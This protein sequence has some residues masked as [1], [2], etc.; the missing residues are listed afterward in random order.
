MNFLADVLKTNTIV[1]LINSKPSNKYNFT[2]LEKNDTIK[3]ALLAF[4]KHEYTSMPLKKNDSEFAGIIKISNLIK[5]IFSQ[6]ENFDISTLLE[7]KLKNISDDFIVDFEYVDPNMSL[8]QLLIDVWNNSCHPKFTHIECNHLLTSGTNGRY[9]IITP[10]DFL[11]YVLFICQNRQTCLDGT[12]A[13]EIENG[14]DVEEVFVVSWNDEA[15]MAMERVIESEPHYLVAVVNEE[16]GTLEANITFTDIFPDN[17]TS[18]EQSI[19]M[20]LS[21]GMSLYS[22]FNSI[23]A[24]LPD[25]SIDP[26]LLYPHFTIYDLIEKLTRLRIHHLWRVT[27]DAIQKPIGAVGVIDVLRYLIFMFSPFHQSNEMKFK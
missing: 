24:L 7:V 19:S 27:P 8:M 1:S 15:R 20:L 4:V 3:T 5:Y 2:C 18:L 25:K 10:M 16:T 13:V 23:H 12:S 26:I 9:E 11:R 17:E 22:Y 6:K 14:F 21:S